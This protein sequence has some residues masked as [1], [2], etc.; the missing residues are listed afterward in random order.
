MRKIRPHD[1]YDLDDC[2]GIAVCLLTS[3][4]VLS[5]FHTLNIWLTRIESLRSLN[6]PDCNRER[7]DK[8]VVF[9][10]TCLL[11]CVSHN[12]NLPVSILERVLD[13]VRAS[14][15]HTFPVSHVSVVFYKSCMTLNRDR[16]SYEGVS[17]TTGTGLQHFIYECVLSTVCHIMQNVN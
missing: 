9:L 16:N 1:T 15:P 6:F 13:C 14:P 3:F 7:A 5:A 12:K 8:A 10:C 17:A 2:Q 4:V 11:Y